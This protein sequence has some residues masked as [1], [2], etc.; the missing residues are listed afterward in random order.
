MPSLLERLRRAPVLLSMQA[1]GRPALRPALALKRYT[2][3]A[4][5]AAAA[6]PQRCTAAA[7]GAVGSSSSDSPPVPRPA[8]E[9]RLIAAVNRQLAA[10]VAEQCG[11]GPE[12]AAHLARSIAQKG[13]DHQAALMQHG[14]DVA[15]LLVNHGI[16][17]PAL[18]ALLKQRNAVFMQPV[19]DVA[20]RLQAML[21]IGLTPAEAAHALGQNLTVPEWDDLPLAHPDL[22]ARVAWLKQL[23]VRCNST[24]SP[25]RILA[26]SV[27][28]PAPS[29][30]LIEQPTRLLESCEAALQQELGGD[31]RLFCRWLCTGP[32]FRRDGGEV[33]RRRA[34]LL[35]QVR[36]ARLGLAPC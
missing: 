9:R 2:H 1:V 5:T 20:A 28:M 10:R 14:R 34:Q 15:A 31:C 33:L 24:F 21:A 18:A 4:T 3:R 11:L 30:R 13:P 35:V 25:Q 26:S 7:A 19:A 27:R 6:R 36:L 22:P 29:M 17:P 8:S 23:A 12:E 32:D 16:E